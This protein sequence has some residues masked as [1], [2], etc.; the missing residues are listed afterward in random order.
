MS[1]TTNE[2]QRRFKARQAEAGL[3]QVNVWLPK[4]AAPEFKQAA[5]AICADPTLRLGSLVSTGTGR[6]VS[7]SRAR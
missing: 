4:F 1:T 3:T 5:E 7:L 6:F 2:R